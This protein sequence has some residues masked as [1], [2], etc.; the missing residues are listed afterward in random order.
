[1]NLQKVADELERLSRKEEKGVVKSQGGTW[2][3][4]QAGRFAGERASA[5]AQAADYFRQM[6]E[7]P[8]ERA[9]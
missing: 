2:F 7:T 6:E 5:L 9:S 4:L 1:M 3:F 8:D